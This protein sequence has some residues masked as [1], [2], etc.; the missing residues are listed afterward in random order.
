MKIPITYY[1]RFW[2]LNT[3]L[4]V[5]TGVVL[6]IL[7]KILVITIPIITLLLSQLF[8]LSYFWGSR[9]GAFEFS[10]LERLEMKQPSNKHIYNLFK[11]AKKE[12]KMGDPI[13]AHNK[14]KEAII[15][16]PNNCVT[17]FKYAISCENMGDAKEAIVAYQIALNNVPTQNKDLL[18]FIERQIERVNTKGPS[19]RS[20]V[21]GLQYVIW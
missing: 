18:E 5:G 12:S 4:A 17:Q 2:L 1:I 8:I 14:L 21:P 16:S 10:F 20:S 13:S 9:R 19:R 15:S 11:E 7:S 3:S 6:G